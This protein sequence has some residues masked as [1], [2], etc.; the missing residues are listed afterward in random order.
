M[1]PAALSMYTNPKEKMKKF[2]KKKN[3]RPSGE[4]FGI[5]QMMMA[6]LCHSSNPVSRLT[7]NGLGQN[8]VQ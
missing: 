8:K 6:C 2:M 5:G 4:N 3:Y 7:F 1:L